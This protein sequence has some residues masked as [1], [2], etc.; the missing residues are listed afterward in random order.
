[1]GKIIA[2]ANQKGGV[3]KTTTSVSLASGLNRMGKKTLLIDTDSQRNS[4]TTYNALSEGV[5]TLYD[6]L[7]CGEDLENCIQKTEAG[8]IIASDSMLEGAESK[9]PTDAGRNYLLR[10]K[11]QELKEKYDYIILDTPPK[12][13]VILTNVLTFADDVVIVLTPASYARDGM[14]A[15]YK[16]VE[17][18][19][20]YTNPALS[21]RGILVNMYYQNQVMSRKLDAELQDISELFHTKIYQTKI[22]GCTACPKSQDAGMTIYKYESDSSA[23]QDYMM[24]CRELEEEENGEDRK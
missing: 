14:G 4:T 22:R 8:D 3:G 16:T 9:F 1:M 12:L 21:I 23:A 17:A 10:E 6:L 24:F 19:K 13:G 15:L 2:I 5:A 20:K 7:F 18:A 11:C